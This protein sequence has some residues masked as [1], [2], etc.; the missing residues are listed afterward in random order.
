MALDNCHECDVF[1]SESSS[2]L[3]D[4]IY[5][6]LY[7]KGQNV[8]RGGVRALTDQKPSPARLVATDNIVCYSDFSQVYRKQFPD[9]ENYY[10]IQM[11]ERYELVGKDVIYV[12]GCAFSSYG[13]RR[14]SFIIPF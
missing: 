10:R 6:L 14:R 4:L 5:E 8:K 13:S 9:G 3:A 11:Q 12:L 2:Y 7:S 1:S